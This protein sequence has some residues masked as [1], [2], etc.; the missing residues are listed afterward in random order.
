MLP[1]KHVDTGMGFERLCM[2][3]QNV[4][5]NYDTDVFTPIISEIEKLSNFKYGDDEQIDIAMRVISD[6]IRAISFSIAD[7][8]LP[9]NVKAGYVIRR[10]LRRAVRY[11]YTFLDLKQ[12]FMYNLVD[13]LCNQMG[14][15]FPELSAQQKLIERV[16]KEEE[17]SFLRTLSEGLK[18]LDVIM[19]NTKKVV[20]GELAFELYDTYGFPLDLTSLIL[21]ENNLELDIDV[22]NQEMEKQKNRSRKATKLVAGE[23]STLFEDDIEEFV[24]YNR[25]ECE[26]KIAK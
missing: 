23:W 3:M 25:L 12:A 2:I 19:Q 17:N 24:G 10:I 18:R 22:F 8:Q 13:V 5:S 16:I 4:K 1:N 21:S 26:V 14:Q 20:S 7:G 15:S 6:H 11:A 9:S